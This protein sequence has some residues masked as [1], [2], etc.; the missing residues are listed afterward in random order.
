M[1]IQNSGVGIFNQTSRRRKGPRSRHTNRALHGQVLLYLRD[2][3]PYRVYPLDIISLGRPN[4]APAQR[5]S[6]VIEGHRLDLGP[7]K[8]HT[9]T[10][11]QA[12]AAYGSKEQG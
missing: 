10:D 9:D 6:T 12:L 7:A 11:A 4:P 2:Q 5:C 3:R 1:S 8:V